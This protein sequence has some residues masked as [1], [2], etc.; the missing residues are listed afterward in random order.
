[1]QFNWEISV[2]LFCTY[3]TLW[4]VS[5]DGIT[6]LFHVQQNLF[7]LE[8]WLIQ[9]K[10]RYVYV[11]NAKEIVAKYTQHNSGKLFNDAESTE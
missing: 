4:F 8:N 11:Y 10:Q 7:Q 2:Q 3:I 9:E 5:S 1:M 6:H